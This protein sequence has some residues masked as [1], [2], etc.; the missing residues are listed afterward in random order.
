[1]KRILIS[2]FLCFQTVFA[3]IQEYN[4][5]DTRVIVCN[6]FFLPVAKVGVF[7][8]AGLNQLKNICESAIVSQKFLSKKTKIAAKNLGIQISVSIY[9]DLSQIS[10]TVSND[11]VTD[12]LK[13]ILNNEFNTENLE[14]TKDRIRISHKLSD[15]F[16]ANITDNQIFSIVNAKNIFN[17]SILDQFT[18]NDLKNIWNIYQKAPK[19]IVICGQLDLEKLNKELSLKKSSFERE[20]TFQNTDIQ[21]KNTELRSKFLGRSL[22]YI[23]Q[24]KNSDIIKNQDAILAVISK[25]MFDYFKKYSQIIDGYHLTNLSQ[26]NFLMLGIRVRRDVSKKFFESN[27]QTFFSRLKRK[28]FSKEKLEQISRAEKF[29]EIDANENIHAKYQNIVNR[30]IFCTQSS[31]KISYKVLK[32]SSDDIKNFV[33][34]VFENNLVSRISTQY[35]AES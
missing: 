31:E 2:L 13:I 5:N 11:Q 20:R 6:D 24:I 30:Y 19:T 35:K 21:K 16:G 23:Y 29:A 28:N 10:A 7:Y 9:D 25:E 3:S 33:E 17:L 15:Y 14:L 4:W 18:E 12:I 8:S 22:Y 34:Q 27:L 1:M 32:I 26:P